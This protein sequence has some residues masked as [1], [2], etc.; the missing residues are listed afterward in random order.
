MTHKFIDENKARLLL[1]IKLDAEHLMERIELRF[2]DYMGTWA[3]KR[4]RT[5]FLDVFKNRYS[6]LSMNDLRL[7]SQ[8]LIVALD[9]FYKEVDE[10]NWYLN[11][12]EDMPATAEEHA[13]RRIRSIKG[14]FSTLHLY[15]EA[16]LGHTQEETNAVS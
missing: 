5:H 9:K 1:L 6:D 4:T 7:F 15:L 3:L 16:E 2:S 12:T 13:Q 8:E 14:H 11:H 10:L